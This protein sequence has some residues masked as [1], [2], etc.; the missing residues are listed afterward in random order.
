MDQVLFNFIS[1]IIT[2]TLMVSQKMFHFSMY[3]LVFS[4]ICTQCRM[5]FWFLFICTG[6][7]PV[8][9]DAPKA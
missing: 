8:M 7:V 5:F 1:V 9:M 3:A 4:G 2:V 6:N